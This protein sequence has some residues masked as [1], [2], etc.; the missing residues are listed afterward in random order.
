MVPQAVDV[1]YKGEGDREG[2]DR[3]VVLFFMGVVAT[4]TDDELYAS[5]LS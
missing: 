2:R 5:A 3:K 4:L 1:T